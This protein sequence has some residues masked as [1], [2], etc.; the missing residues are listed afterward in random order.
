MQLLNSKAER[1]ELATSIANW[2]DEAMTFLDDWVFQVS[3][4]GKYLPGSPSRPSPGPFAYCE[5]TWKFSLVCDPWTWN[6]RP[7]RRIPHRQFEL[8]EIRNEVHRA[9]TVVCHNLISPTPANKL[10]ADVRK[11]HKLKKLNSKDL[12]GDD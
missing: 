2:L 7:N 1:L 12:F 11:K 10:L 5:G 8:D 4:K 6:H 9:V 3:R